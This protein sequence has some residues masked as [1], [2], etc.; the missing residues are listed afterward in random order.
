MKKIVFLNSSMEAGGPGRVIAIWAK[1]FSEKGLPVEIVSNINKKSFFKLSR[2]IEF[3]V[4]NIDRF[5]QRSFFKTL[6][7]LYK[8]F[9][10]R[11]NEIMLFNKGSYVLYI[12]LLRKVKLINESISLIYIVH[13]GSSNFALKYSNA[14]NKLIFSTFHNVVVLHDDFGKFKF[15]H[16]S[17]RNNSIKRKFINYI[18]DFSWQEASKKITY[19]PNPVSI[20]T[21]FTPNYDSKIVLTVGRLDIVKGHAYLLEA[22]SNI[23]KKYKDWQLYIVGDGD[24]RNNLIAHIARLDLAKTVQLIP[25]TANVSKFYLGST[26]FVNSSLEEGMPMVVLEAME[27]SLP[28]VAFPSTGCKYLVRNK[29][30]GLICKNF[31]SKELSLNIEMLISNKIK[32]IRYGHNS[33][34]YA[35]EFYAENLVPKW[36]RLL[37]INSH[38]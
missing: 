20:R 5:E 29:R 36:N 3:T 6:F 22:W 38:A 11:V 27:F 17:I 37:E 14:F 32:R 10:M 1:F 33:K 25:T 15:T 2:K 23:H 34:K 4:L 28:I 13:G 9:K 24:E 8:F 12:Y 16:S 18:F 21:N 31:D 30:N 19:I 26:I 35:S 7:I